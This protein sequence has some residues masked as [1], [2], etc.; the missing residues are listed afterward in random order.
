MKE[1]KF[2]HDYEKLPLNWEGTI[3]TLVDV[4]REDLRAIREAAPCFIE[5]DTKY[6]N[7]E[8]SYNLDFDDAII[9]RFE[10]DTASFTTIRKYT[11]DK[12]KYY[13][14]SKGEKFKMVRT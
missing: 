1:I 11:L 2:S 4:I 10:T 8:G 12:W 14:M 5:W 6:R 13:Y 7:E 3:A 9:L